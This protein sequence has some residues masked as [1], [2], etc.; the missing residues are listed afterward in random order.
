[1]MKSTG[2][3]RKVIYTKEGKIGIVKDLIIENKGQEVLSPSTPKGYTSPDW[4]IRP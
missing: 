2:I 1:M 3:V 4:D